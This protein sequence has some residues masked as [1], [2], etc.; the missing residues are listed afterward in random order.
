MYKLRTEI[1][2]IIKHLSPHTRESI[3]GHQD[4]YTTVV[5][6]TDM[7]KIYQDVEIYAQKLDKNIREA[8]ANHP[9]ITH[10]E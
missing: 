4:A 1:N 3:F 5:N 7:A 8:L 9:S 6:E 2:E 10:P